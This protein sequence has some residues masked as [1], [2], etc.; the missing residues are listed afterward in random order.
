MFNVCV[1][2]YNSDNWHL[3]LH[4]K[5]PPNHTTYD[6]TGRPCSRFRAWDWSIFDR[7]IVIPKFWKNHKSLTL[8]N[9]LNQFF[10]SFSCH[11]PFK[12]LEILENLEVEPRVF[13]SNA[14][15]HSWTCI[16]SHIYT[17]ALHTISYMDDSNDNNSDCSV[18]QQR[19]VRHL[20]QVKI[21]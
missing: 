21:L 7:K 14:P 10:S 20:E 18:Q 13:G 6:N 3:P 11:L 8:S 5:Y 1:G 17:L 9:E 2:N 4:L 19:L 16:H 15:V 12:M